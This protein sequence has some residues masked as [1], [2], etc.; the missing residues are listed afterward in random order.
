MFSNILA[1]DDGTNFGRFPWDY[2][3]Y[4]RRSPDISW[5]NKLSMNRTD[6]YHNYEIVC[7]YV[8][9]YDSILIVAERYATLTFYEAYRIIIS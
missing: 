4:I 2:L 8:S 7:K 3:V 6:S 5:Y 9:Y 1:V